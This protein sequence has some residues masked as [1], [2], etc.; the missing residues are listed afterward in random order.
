MDAQQWLERQ[1]GCRLN[2]DALLHQALSH[3]SVGSRNNERLEFLGDS[4]LGYV[5]SE[6]LYR[7][8]PDADEGQLSRLRV[9]LVK[10][11]ALAEV[12][13]EITLGEQLRLGVG[14]RHGGGRRRN[15]ILA[16]SFE[17][18]LG[19]IVLDLGI[20]ACRAAILKVFHARFEGLK[21][22]QARKDPKTRLQELLQGSGR[23]LPEY[24]LR[25]AT[26][27]DHARI[28][29]VACELADGREVAEGIGDSRRA[30]EQAAASA[31]L[32]QLGEP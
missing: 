24:V 26:G 16:D 12:A 5:V 19:A 25:K 31:V 23:P 11:S 22:E 8:F 27:E 10:G 28:F 4:V 15:S 3:R 13:R 30:A 7:R 20:E 2:N 21:L 14:E 18:I 32:E 17:A 9:S 6:E 1:F 29:T